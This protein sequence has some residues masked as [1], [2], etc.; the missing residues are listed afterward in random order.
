MKRTGAFLILLIMLSVS[1]DKGGYS[2]NTGNIVA[3]VSTNPAGFLFFGPSLNAGW[4]IDEKTMLHADVRRSSWGLLAWKIRASDS[5]LSGFK[6][7]GYALGAHRYIHSIQEGIYYGGFLSLDIQDTK[8]SEDQP[9]SWHER[10]RSIGL[11]VSAGKRFKLGSRYY[12]NAGGVLGGAF[13]KYHWEYDDLS[14]GLS[15]TEARKGN[16]F[17]PIGSLEL[18]FGMFLFQ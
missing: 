14:A 4:A 2:Q 9:F 3:T 8:Y 5:S 6:G 13:L 15:D 7:M 12:F 17:I 1:P 10:T 18:A 11:L 16:S